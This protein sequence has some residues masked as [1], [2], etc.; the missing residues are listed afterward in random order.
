MRCVYKNLKCEYKLP[1]LETAISAST[2]ACQVRFGDPLF[3]PSCLNLHLKNTNLSLLL[4]PL[5]VRF[6]VDGNTATSSKIS[7]AWIFLCDRQKH[8]PPKYHCCENWV[9]RIPLG[10]KE[11]KR[12]S[13]KEIGIDLAR[14][15]LVTNSPTWSDRERWCW[16]EDGTRS[17]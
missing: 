2:N 4:V 14:D 6:Q 15:L 13:F 7:W 3:R 1:L 12:T 17:I 11:K 9:C 10:R 8:V 16:S 5:V